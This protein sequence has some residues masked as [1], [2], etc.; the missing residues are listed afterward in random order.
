ME[1]EEASANNP[2]GNFKGDIKMS[3]VSPYAELMETEK[4]IIYYLCKGCT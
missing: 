3:K 1:D 4:I 2:H